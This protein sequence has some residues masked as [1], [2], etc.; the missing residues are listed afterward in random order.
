M[1]N[2]HIG[3][4]LSV[5]KNGEVA[6]VCGEIVVLS[7][8]LYEISRLRLAP[9]EHK[10]RLN[11]AAELKTCDIACFILDDLSNLNGYSIKTCGCDTLNLLD[12]ESHLAVR[13]GVCTLHIADLIA[14][15]CFPVDI[16]GLVVTLG[17][18]ECTGCLCAEELKA[19]V[20]EHGRGVKGGYENVV[21]IAALCNL[22][23]SNVVLISLSRKLGKLNVN[24]I[25][26]NVDSYR[27]SGL[28]IN[29]LY[30]VRG[31]GSG[32]LVR[33]DGGSTLVGNILLATVAEVSNN[34]HTRG[35]N[36][37]ANFVIKLC[38]H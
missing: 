11:H 30:V 12:L 34:L 32:D 23:R 9:A 36:G 37:F 18:L 8:T 1:I 20:N 19:S 7:I 3:W 17:V 26:V 38:G 28:L 24:L 22:V 21:G 29:V 2:V 35:I 14:H 10:V 25:Y 16:L 27:L 6:N 5:I 13:G 33:A 4:N 31:G 15:T